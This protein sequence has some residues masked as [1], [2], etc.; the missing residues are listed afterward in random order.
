MRD[1]TKA[2]F[3]KKNGETASSLKC[4][5]YTISISYLMCT[6]LAIWPMV[7]YSYLI[8]MNLAFRDR[9]HERCPFDNLGWRKNLQRVCLRNICNF[10][11]FH[12]SAFM[13]LPASAFHN[14]VNTRSWKFRCDKEYL[15]HMR[16]ITIKRRPA[17]RR[18]L[19]VIH[20]QR[21]WNQQKAFGLVGYPLL[22]LNSQEI[23]NIMAQNFSTS[24]TATL[25]PF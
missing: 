23:Q 14:T 7:I 6:Q 1:E 11:W 24:R 2:N 25:F 19:K 18:Y 4:F 13:R 8:P 9:W 20:C 16:H 12:P 22:S 3:G 10:M 17:R 15:K 5:R 21:S